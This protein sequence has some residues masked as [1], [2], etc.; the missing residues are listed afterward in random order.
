MLQHRQRNKYLWR[1]DDLGTD[2]CLWRDANNGVMLAIEFDLLADDIGVACEMRSPAAVSEDGHGMP[3]AFDVIGCIQQS[4]SDGLNAQHVEVIS[5]NRISPKTGI[6]SVATAD[7]ERLKIIHRE[8]AEHGIPFAI[9][10]VVGVGDHGALASRGVAVEEDEFVL[11]LDSEGP[12][13]H[14]IYQG[15]DSGV[16]ANA[17]SENDDGGSRKA[18]ARTEAAECKA[19]I[20]AEH[21]GSL[22][23]SLLP[24]NVRCSQSDSVIECPILGNIGSRAVSSELEGG[25]FGSV[26]ISARVAQLHVTAPRRVTRYSRGWR[27]ALQRLGTISM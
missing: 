11:V 5:A 22:G 20:V 21:G 2:E 18:R 9:V 10:F 7:V 6:L 15:E 4:A 14:G 27:V 12:E 19:Q 25:P 13:D 3:P 26:L 23:A 17:K 8:V 16:G 1:E 24:L